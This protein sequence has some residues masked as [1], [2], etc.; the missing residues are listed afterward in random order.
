MITKTVKVISKDGIHMRPCGMIVDAAQSYD[1][2]ITITK[3]DGQEADAKSMMSITMLAILHG[4]EITIIANGDDEDNAVDAI[5][6]LIESDFDR[7][8]AE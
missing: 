5:V 3:N 8:L 2:D 1:C 4:E 6:E 7:I